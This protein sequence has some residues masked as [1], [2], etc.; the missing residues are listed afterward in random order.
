MVEAE[1]PTDIEIVEVKPEE[2]LQPKNCNRC[3]FFRSVALG[4]S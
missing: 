2:R 4:T 1:G 3:R